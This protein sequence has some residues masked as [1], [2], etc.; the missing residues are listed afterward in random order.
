MSLL[1]QSALVKSALAVTIG[2]GV[3]LAASAC[4]S[5]Q[6]SQTATQAPAV[7]GATVRDG[8]L[9]VNDVQIVYPEGDSAAVFAAG[10]PFKLAFVA[11]NDDPVNDAKLVSITAPTGTVAVPGD[12]VVKPG[13]ALRAGK[14]AGMISAEGAKS[15][16]ITFSN[17]GKTVAPGLTVP[18]TFTFDTAGKT[19]NIKVET[20][21]DVGSLAERKDKDPSDDIESGHH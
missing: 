7:N 2:A 18:L 13:S 6:V 15:V 5:G 9:A 19:T 3:V 1:S 20:P 8:G 12:A 4:G 16:D 11:T 10:G 17:T 14:P 21:V